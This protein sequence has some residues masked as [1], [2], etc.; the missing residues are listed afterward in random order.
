M[1]YFTPFPILKLYSKNA[2]TY[3][4]QLELL[5][6]RG[7]I[8][9]NEDKALHLLEVLSYYRLSGYLYPQLKLPK[10]EHIFKEES[11][12]ESAF[13]MYKFDRE[14]RILIGANVEKIEIAFRAKLTYVLA[15][16]YDAFWYTY[17]KLFKKP[18]LQR[19]SIEGIRKAMQDSTEDFV[20]QYQKKYLDNFLPSWMALEIVTFSHLSKIY[21]N[22]KDTSAKSEIAKFFG[23]P[24][25]LMENWLLLITYTRNIC[26]HHSRFWNRELSLKSRKITTDLPYDWIDT[27]G[28]PRNK[29]YFYISVIKYLL[30]RIN[31]ENNFKVKLEDLFSKY[32][33]IDYTKSMGFPENWRDQP[34]WK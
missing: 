13:K 21:E 5:K 34:L 32:E 33:N 8:I 12:F 9:E 15:H 10:E 17:D 11:Y 16:R 3:Y 4:Q 18:D 25:Q 20:I 31:P 26:A 19:T 2:L 28:I 7:L 27:S 29:S 22:L 1:F 23:L 30:D 6:E 14:L 24:Y